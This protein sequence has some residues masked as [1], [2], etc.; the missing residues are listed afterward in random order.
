MKFLVVLTCLWQ[1]FLDTW[2]NDDEPYDPSWM[3]RNAWEYSRI[4]R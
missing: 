3:D 4:R 2:F 1:E